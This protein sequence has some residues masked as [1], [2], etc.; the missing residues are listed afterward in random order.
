MP[1]SVVIDGVEYFRRANTKILP[2]GGL[3]DFLRV[4][5]LSL[6]LTLESASSIIGCSKSYL[7]EL[8]N[9]SSDPSLSMAKSIA[10]AYGVSVEVLSSYVQVKNPH[11]E[12]LE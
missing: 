12:T 9:D 6:R 5:R 3:G 11:K 8:E 4:L 1:K 2:D 10:H 7:W